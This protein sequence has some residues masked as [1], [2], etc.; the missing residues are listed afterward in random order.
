M[1]VRLG[2][3]EEKIAG[4]AGLDFL[5]THPSSS[6]RVQVSPIFL[7][8]AL[9][10]PYHYLLKILIQKLE[11]ILPDAYAV[12]AANPD[13][14]AIQDRL[15]LFRAA[16]EGQGVPMAGTGVGAGDDAEMF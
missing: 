2:R 4:R 7:S 9:F 8:P 13:C 15:Q 16:A 6:S 11:Q 5:Q 12:L 14:A 1:F 3:I 10:L